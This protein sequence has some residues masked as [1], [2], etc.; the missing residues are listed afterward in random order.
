MF[1]AIQSLRIYNTVLIFALQPCTVQPGKDTFM[2]CPMP[3]LNIP[4]DFLDILNSLYNTSASRTRRNVQ[5]TDQLISLYRNL[6]LSRKKRDTNALT[7]RGPN[8]IDQLDIYLG[9]TLDGYKKYENIN[10][11]LPE[12]RFNFYSAPEINSSTQLLTF[13]ASQN[14]VIYI[15]G[16]FMLRGCRMRDYVVQIGNQICTNSDLQDNQ[17]SCRPPKVEPSSTV[18][19]MTHCNPHLS[20]TVTV[21]YKQYQ[22]ACLTYIQHPG[23]VY[24][25]Q[26]APKNIALIVGLSVGLG[27]FA[28]FLIILII[29]CIVRRR[30][31]KVRDDTNT[32]DNTGNRSR[33]YKT[34]DDKVF[35]S[36]NMHW[37]PRYDE[38]AVSANDE[39]DVRDFDDTNNNTL[40]N[41]GRL[42]FRGRNYTTFDDTNTLGNLGRLEFR[43]GNYA[44]FDDKVFPKSNMHWRTRYDEDAVSANHEDVRDSDGGSD[45]SA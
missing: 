38:D 22:Y 13:D 6:L 28:I 11:A 8:E 15:K 4:D 31:N 39:D 36:S 35:S 24:S 44:T 10:D 33:N 17:L 7:I 12:T 23:F 43:S 20:I 29:V 18:N 40:G 9:F 25:D 42:E 30:R 37:R 5:P 2:Q 41:T 14:E 27:L 19:D 21:G 45:Y 26:S 3:P 1:S 16:R 32:P 34:F